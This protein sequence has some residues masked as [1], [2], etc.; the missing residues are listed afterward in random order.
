MTTPSSPGSASLPTGPSGTLGSTRTSTTRPSRSSRPPRYW[1][2]PRS[3]ASSTPP[4]RANGRA[5]HGCRLS[6]R[7]SY[8]AARRILDAPEMRKLKAGDQANITAS[9]VH[10]ID[11]HPVAV[12]IAKTHMM[13][14]LP[15]SPTAGASAIQIRMGD[16]LMAENQGTNLFDVGGAMRIV[17]PKA[18]E[19]SLPMSFV[20]RP[21]FPD[22]MRRLVGAA[23]EKRVPTTFV[24][25]YTPR[26]QLKPSGA[27]EPASGRGRPAAAGDRRGSVRKKR[28]FWPNSSAAWNMTRV[29]CSVSVRQNARN[30]IQWTGRR[31]RRSTT[32]RIERL[33][34]RNAGRLDGS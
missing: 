5:S 25:K 20:R 12:E 32:L 9:L 30:R 4:S 26:A 18:R 29:P 15:T 28:T 1:T 17:T 11:V 3:S 7:T 34:S 31:P 21:S 16:S 24:Q 27:P 22:D 23:I 2:P 13:R 8:H 33:S 6:R 19:I 14:V 10:G